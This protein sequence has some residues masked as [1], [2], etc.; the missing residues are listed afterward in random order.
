ML[1]LKHI[2]NLTQH[3]PSIR[4]EKTVPSFGRQKQRFSSSEFAPCYTSKGTC[5][6]TARQEG[7]TVRFHFTKQNDTMQYNEIVT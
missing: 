1:V 7:H 3:P 4:Q 6:E 2:Q 5:Q